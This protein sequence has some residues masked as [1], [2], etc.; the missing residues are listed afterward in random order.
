MNISLEYYKIFYYV[1]KCKSITAAAGELCISQ[2]GLGA[3]QDVHYPTGIDI[4]LGIVGH[5]PTAF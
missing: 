5:I 3:A 1:A 4:H 2:P